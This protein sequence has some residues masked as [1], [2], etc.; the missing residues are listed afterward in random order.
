MSSNSV[1]RLEIPPSA[2]RLLTTVQS[3]S[4]A[5]VV[6]PHPQ[7]IPTPRKDSRGRTGFPHPP[8]EPPRALIEILGETYGVADIDYMDMERVYKTVL[9]I[10]RPKRRDFHQWNLDHLRIVRLAYRPIGLVI[11]FAAIDSPN[12][13]PLPTRR[14]CGV[15]F[16]RTAGPFPGGSGG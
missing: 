10:E 11:H 5:V 2:K 12:F 9:Y 13:P 8:D 6:F 7:T 4:S 3:G 1:G 16:P 14:E 15:T